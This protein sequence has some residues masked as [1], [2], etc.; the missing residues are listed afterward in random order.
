MS[1]EKNLV[2]FQNVLA[3][4]DNVIYKFIMI[5]YI[6]IQK[7][8]QNTIEDRSSHIFTLKFNQ[9]AIKVTICLIMS[10][11]LVSFQ[12]SNSTTSINSRLMNPKTTRV[13]DYLKSA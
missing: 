10:S 2:I 11:L 6:L 7:I 5:N 3:H 8:I 9:L 1:W 13:S 12:V 4:L